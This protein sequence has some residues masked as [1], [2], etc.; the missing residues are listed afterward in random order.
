MATLFT[1]GDSITEGAQSTSAAKRYANL[2]ASALGATLDN[3][4]V[5]TAMVMDQYSTMFSKM[6]LYG[7]IGTVAFGTN[8]Q[9]KY[10]LDP[11][12]RGYFIDGIT[13]YILWVAC[14]PRLATAANGVAFTGTWSNAGLA[15]GCYASSFPGAKATFTASGSA[16]VLGMYRQFGNA[17]TFRV[18][19]DGVD[20]GLFSTNGDVRTILG[21]AWGPM[22]L[23]FDGLGA[24][25][26]SVEIEVVT[27][28]SAANIVYFHWFC[29]LSTARNRVAV[30]NIPQAI[31]Y[32]YGGSAANVDAYNADIAALVAR[33]ATAG[34]DVRLADVSSALAP[35]D[36]FDNVHPN[37]AGHAKMAIVFKN[38]LQ[39]ADTATPP[40]NTMAYTPASVHS[41]SDGN[42]Y[43]KAGNGPY[44]KLTLS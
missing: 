9:A 18:R 26:H 16:I 17:S 27:G 43:A 30:G 25:S 7:D 2:L 12:K 33:L 14:Q 36:M 41:G 20:K 4:G 38:S 10:D 15:L 28:G 39:Q 21:T 11:A 42:F 5:S 32:T 35:S 34:A 13:A 31:A 19:I 8:D 6:P 29:S 37:D 44:K 40:A 22:C 23:V 3:S 24:G 1:F